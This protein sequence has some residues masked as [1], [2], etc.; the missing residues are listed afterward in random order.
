MSNS[1]YIV[2]GSCNVTAPLDSACPPPVIITDTNGG[3]GTDPNFTTTPRIVGK[4]GSSTISWDIPNATACTLTGNGVN[5]VAGPKGS[6]SS[7]ILNSTKVF[8]LT[9]EN[10]GGAT[11]PRVSADIK[12][13]VL[14]FQEF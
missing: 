4:G 12:V 2:N 3:G 1:G 11:S 7:G 9:C 5:V 10:G 13:I 14:E 8:T 6:A